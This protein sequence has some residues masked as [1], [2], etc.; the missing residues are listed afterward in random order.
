M[1]SG[2]SQLVGRSLG[3]G[4]EFADHRSY[5][6]GD[7]IRFLDWP[8]YA[9]TEKL[10]VRLFSEHSESDVAILQDVSASMAAGLDGK[11]GWDG[12]FET[13][14]RLATALAFVSMGS[15]RRVSIQPFADK[16]VTPA[17]RPGRRREM[18]LDVLNSLLKI[19]PAG[20]TNLM[21]CVEDFLSQEKTLPRVGTILLIS[22]LLDCSDDLTRA[23]TL[24][25]GPR[26]QRQLIVL[27][28]VEKPSADFDG[29]FLLL[30]DAETGK[31]LQ[32][33]LTPNVREA[34]CHQLLEFQQQ[35]AKSCIAS[36]GQYIPIQAGQP[37]EEF[38]LHTLHQAGVVRQ[39]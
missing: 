36:G 15:A 18:I 4:L 21:G 2:A 17:I 8:C 30:R 31:N 23:F 32:L 13:A 5:C 7:D 26:C 14:I 25:A 11:I 9:R 12:K 22:D 34:Y 24:L 33:R 28:T 39:Q 35:V 19:E 1:V 3:D 27:H 37:I 10:L 6:P 38:V 20:L 29:E 16:L